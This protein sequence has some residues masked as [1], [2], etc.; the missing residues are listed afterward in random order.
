MKSARRDLS[1][2]S[3]YEHNLRNDIRYELKT[4]RSNQR[5]SKKKLTL[6]KSHQNFL[7]HMKGY[8]DRRNHRMMKLMIDKEKKEISELKNMGHAKKRSKTDSSHN[9]NSNIHEKL[10][11]DSRLKIMRIKECKHKHKFDDLYSFS[12]EKGKLS[13]KSTEER[14]KFFIPKIN[15]R[16]KKLIRKNSK[17]SKPKDTVDI[18]YKDAKHR[19]EH[20]NQLISSKISKPS[21][22]PKMLGRSRKILIDNFIKKYNEVMEYLEVEETAE[23]QVQYD[24]Y[25]VVLRHI[26]FFDNEEEAKISESE[27]VFEGWRAMSGDRN[28]YVTRQGLKEFMIKALDLKQR[29]SAP[30]ESD[31]KSLKKRKEERKYAIKV[32]KDNESE[33]RLDPSDSYSE[34][35]RIQDLYRNIK[36][37]K[38]SSEGKVNSRVRNFFSLKMKENKQKARKYQNQIEY[39]K[40]VNSSMVYFNA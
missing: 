26:I 9:S 40:D 23:A 22:T 28:G 5:N 21:P 3:L 24:Q 32:G 34:N 25:L 29:Q 36:Y 37:S 30:V 17:E 19:S 7:E 15:K 14:R 16:S 10:Y 1:V 4:E 2:K 35:T 31:K 12:N 8:E 6:H 27:E 38:P 33:V 13:S 39:I 11:D 20:R 18:L